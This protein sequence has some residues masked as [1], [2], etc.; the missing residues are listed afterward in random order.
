MKCKTSLTHNTYSVQ[1]W[2]ENDGKQAAKF[3][4]VS[5][6]NCVFFFHFTDGLSLQPI[7]K[8]DSL[9]VSKAHVCISLW[10]LGGRG[11]YTSG[12]KWARKCE[13]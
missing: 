5:A 3:G 13:L 12:H 1:S 6:T 2:H 4:S 9:A 7:L 11:K 8:C 10:V